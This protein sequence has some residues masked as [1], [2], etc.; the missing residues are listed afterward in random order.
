MRKHN[1]SSTKPAP[2][3]RYSFNS[4]FQAALSRS[5]QYF[6]RQKLSIEVNEMTLTKLLKTITSLAQGQAQLFYN[7]IYNGSQI[8]LHTSKNY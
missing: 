3:T 4:G 1:I 8:I 2:K 6:L 7:N 5:N